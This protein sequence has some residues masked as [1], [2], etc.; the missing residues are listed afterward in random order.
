MQIL[1]PPSVPLIGAHTSTAGGLQNA[2]YE[3]YN[4]GASTVQ[5]FTANQRQ[6]RRRPLTDSTVAS[7]KTALEETSLSHI[8]SHAG[9][10][11]NPGAPNP[12]ILEKSRI[13]IHQEIQ[14]CIS[15]GITFVN[16][17]PGAAIKSSKEECLDKIIS[18]FALTQSL[19]EDS[20]PL[21][22]LFETT[23]GQG[24][25][26][27]SKF[28]ELDY[29]IQGLKEKIPVGICLDTCHIFA[30]GYDI[31]SKEGWKQVLKQFDD[32]IG[33]SYLRAI[34]LNDSIFPL[35]KNKDRHAPLGEGYIGME[36][37]EFL[38]T[39]EHTRLI[40]KYLETPGGPDLWTKEIQNLCKLTK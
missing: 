27:G 37:F 3:G 38:M 25:L 24:S 4:I 19:F 20:P 22:V 33:L 16:F 11:I 9:Y 1:N 32:I 12:E 34:H 35:G 31:S 17:H 10:L 23:A 6:W 29:L 28:E 40:P 8:M 14:D 30:A 36:S 26:V 13:C 21:M 5:I 2:L 18:S 15:L 39:N 7:F